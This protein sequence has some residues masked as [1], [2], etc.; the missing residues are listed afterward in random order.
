MMD[1]DAHDSRVA[2]G[3]G[4]CHRHKG[5]AMRATVHR[6]RLCWCTALVV[7]AI[8]VGSS[9]VAN[10][11][12]PDD[13]ELKAIADLKDHGAKLKM[14]DD[15]HVV[16]VS[17]QNQK[18]VK[19]EW[20]EP[21]K[22]LRKLDRVVLYR[23]DTPDDAL[24]HLKECKALT[25]LQLSLETTDEGAK[26]LSTLT[27]LKYLNFGETKVTDDGIAH[28]AKLT[29]LSKLWLTQKSFTGKGLKHL[30]QL[31]SLES[32]YIGT[33]ELTDESLAAVRDMKQLVNIG[34][35]NSQVT[36]DGLMQLQRLRK[37]KNVIASNSRVTKE[38]AERLMAL[39]PGCIVTYD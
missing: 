4:S 5:R 18:G 20:L 15:G 29:Q 21:L 35:G 24:K 22:L 8:S 37:L 19:S 2:V 17:F 6:I 38:G 30:K 14:D 3:E 1:R 32:L 34:I 26:H 13:A 39:L 9:V 25:G 36:D 11:A 7:I 12:Q 33:P 16:S 23:S 31:K 27:N 28:I 10:A